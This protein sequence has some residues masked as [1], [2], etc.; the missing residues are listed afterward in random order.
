[1]VQK[2]NQEAPKSALVVEG[3]AMRGIFAAGVLDSFIDSGYRPFDFCIGVSAGSTN[4]AA[5]L[6]NQRGRSYKV[7][8][9]Y[10]CRP[11]FIDFK[12]FIKGGHWLD[13]DWLWDITIREI[14]IDA[15]AMASQ[16]IPLYVVT[17]K[18]QTGEA[19]YIQATPDN[20]NELLKASCSVP[21][22]YR[23]YPQIGDEPMTDGGVADSIP[24]VKA[25]EMGARDI[26]VVLSRP[27]G[28]TKS[29]VKNK[30]LVKKLLSEHPIL[31]EAMI[32]RADSYNRAIEFVNSPP[33]DCTLHVIAPPESFA[34]G[35]ITTDWK[36]LNAGYQLGIDASKSLNF[37]GEAM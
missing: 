26:T 17:T 22:A 31:A 28:Y 21:I 10:S 19:V 35:R 3:G 36:K 9:D 8:T 24:V 33:E 7:I 37:A 18:V 25:Y 30:W 32:S 6:A 16:P 14:N 12:R 15:E 29:Q 11:E 20:L 27:L 34:V 1:M 2:I 13:L 5:W 23:Q 4:L